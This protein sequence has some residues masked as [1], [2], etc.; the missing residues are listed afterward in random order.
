MPKVAALVEIPHDRGLQVEIGK[1]KILLVRDGEQVR[2]YSGTCPHAGAP[3]AEGAICEGRILCP[4]HKAAFRISDGA[5]MEPPALD[6]LERFA[7]RL[8]G[9]DVHVDATPEPQRPT[10]RRAD[11]RSFVIVGAGAAGATAAAALREFGFGGRV[12]LIGRERGL[13]YD[14]TSLSKF[15]V[16]GQ[17]KPEETPPLRPEGFYAQQ[18]IERIEAEVAEFDAPRRE[19]TLAD[20][21]KLAFDAALLAP[22]GE[23]KRLDIPGAE[24]GGVHVLR[25]REDAAA[26]LADVRPGARAV[27][28]GGSFI[29]LE[30]ASSLREQKAEVAVVMPDEIPFV[31]QFGK[32]IGQSLRALHEANGVVFFS[33]AKP[34]RLDGGDHVEALVLEDGRR[35]PADLV[36]VGVGVSPA[37]RFVKG[38]ELAKDGGLPVDASLRAVEAIYVAGDAAAFPAPG[39]ERTRIEHWRVA[40]QQARIAAANLLG[41]SARFET[42]PFF[43]TYHYGQNFDYLGHA[44]SWDEEAIVGD[45]EAQ[46]F[47]ALLLQGERVAAVVACQRQRLTAALAQRMSAP[48]M[49]EEALRLVEA[50]S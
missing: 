6:A 36:V 41:G 1:Q 33:P 47:V 29:G 48:L 7:V 28:I 22:G 30:A 50:L 32:R 18:G 24:L 27:V 20:G 19:L 17:M 38:L 43:W 42:T 2:A 49:R 13:P 34:A 45:V 11:A 9:G 12:Q 31:K 16:A 46:N 23:P 8:E 5:L 10:T 4:W 26:I 14:R 21:R 25:S 3:L 15:V 40:Q 37:T 39:G 44:S 35:L